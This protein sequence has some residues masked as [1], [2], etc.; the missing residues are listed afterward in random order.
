MDTP[1]WDIPEP[2]MQRYRCEH[3]YTGQCRCHRTSHSAAA[4]G[5]EP[6]DRRG[7]QG[8]ALGYW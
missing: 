6:G 2:P 5:Y 7:Y 8:L 1:R 3:G 4:G